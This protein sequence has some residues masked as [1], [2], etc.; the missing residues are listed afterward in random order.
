MVSWGFLRSHCRTFRSIF[1]CFFYLKNVY[2]RITLTSQMLMFSTKDA[3]AKLTLNRL[4]LVDGSSFAML[5]R[6]KSGD[7]N[8]WQKDHVPL[9]LQQISAELPGSVS[10]VSKLLLDFNKRRAEKFPT[11]VSFPYQ[12][13]SNAAVRAN[14]PHFLLLF[15][16][17]VT[18]T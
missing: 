7:P 1:L 5:Y 11:T 16:F 13:M 4:T 14:P 9:V 2:L 8:V 6:G 12:L 17:L 10:H 3:Q 15:F 18:W